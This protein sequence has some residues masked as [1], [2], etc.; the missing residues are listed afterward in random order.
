MPPEK[1]ILIVAI[2][3]IAGTLAIFWFLPDAVE[4][5]APE[6]LAA[7]V[8]IQ[9]A[10]SEVAEVGP[11]EI[12]AGEEF[13][14]H[15][16]LEARTRGGDPLYYTE[17]ERLSLAG[18]EIPVDQIRVWNRPGRSQILWFT[19]EGNVPFIK[20][21]SDQDLD[22]FTLTEFLHLEW[23]RSWSVPGQ[24]EPANDNGFQGGGETHDFGTQRYQARIEL[25]ATEDGKVPMAR[26]KS[27][28]A[29]ELAEE[30]ESFATVSS[31]LPGA[32]GPAS[33]Y[34]GLTAIETPAEPSSEYLAEVSALTRSRLA[35]APLPL[36]AEIF[37]RAGTTP[38]ELEWTRVDLEEG[39][40]WGSE[41][42]AGDL[43]QVGARW[44]MLLE[45]AGTLGRLDRQDLCLD[46]E[47]RPAVRRLAE[48]FTG[49]GEL[50]LGRLAQSQ[51]G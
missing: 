6:P 25:F 42:D 49:E 26:F 10:G 13:T 36:L 29:T 50:E 12:E 39:P 21:E 3:A 24:L 43:L 51:G 45:D 9:P 15:A 35:Y 48:V 4:R 37:H 46:F 11:V 8:A 17:A 18:Q 28:G 32:P 16:V 31:R 14:L 47:G 2:V 22:R 44:V 40:A 5:F 33:L 7:W 27:P 41:A 23:P 1:K 38:D 34:F 20:L 30:P 19:V